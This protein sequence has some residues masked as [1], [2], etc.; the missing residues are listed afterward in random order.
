VNVREKDMT[1]RIKGVYVA[2]DK[3]YR[4]DDAESILTAIRQIRGVALVSSQVTD[5]VDFDA[6]AKVREKFRSDIIK[7]YTDLA[8]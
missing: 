7:L 3:D 1:D 5:F 4:I 8:K 6:R 2:F